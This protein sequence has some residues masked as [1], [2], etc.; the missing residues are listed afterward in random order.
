MKFTNLR[1]LLESVTKY[2][3]N[4]KNGHLDFNNRIYDIFHIFSTNYNI[5]NVKQITN[6]IKN[7]YFK[8]PTCYTHE[9]RNGICPDCKSQMFT[10]RFR[11]SGYNKEASPVVECRVDRNIP[12][13]IGLSRANLSWLCDHPDLEFIVRGTLSNKFIFHHATL[14]PCNDSPGKI[15]IAFGDWHMNIHSQLKNCYIRIGTLESLVNVKFDQKIQDEL[16]VL[17]SLR[18]SLFN[19]LTSIDDD[20]DI[21]NLL[22]ELNDRIKKNLI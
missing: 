9:D 19:R 14:D 11:G 8:C 2:K 3:E 4:N 20:P 1:S 17:Y 6:S 18:S 22:Y 13:T 15:K 7:L 10:F 21:M 12:E 16:D 5:N